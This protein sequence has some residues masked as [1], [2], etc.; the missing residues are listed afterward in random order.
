MSNPLKIAESTVNV[1]LGRDHLAQ[2]ALDEMTIPELEARVRTNE[3]RMRLAR[4]AEWFAGFG[5]GFLGALSVA[6]MMK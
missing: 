4:Q 3:E 1:V 5:S 6:K 2:R